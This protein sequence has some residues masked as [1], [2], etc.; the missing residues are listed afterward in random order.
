[1]DETVI[2]VRSTD[3]DIVR[4]VLTQVSAT[5]SYAVV[6]MP[7]GNGILTLQPLDGKLAASLGGN[8]LV[9]SRGLFADEKFATAS[10]SST[11][12]PGRILA[13]VQDLKQRFGTPAIY[14]IGTSNSTLS[15]MALASPLDGQVAGF[16][17]TSSRNAIGDLD[18]HRFKSRHLLV[19]NRKDRCKWCRPSFAQASHDTY[20]TDLIMMD[21]GSNSDTDT[22][23]GDAGCGPFNYHGY[24]GIEKETVD[25]I[26]A[27][28]V[29]GK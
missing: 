17:H 9:R 22:T 10:T 20:G 14:V 19:A 24:N 26:K 15:T 23:P 27:W 21:G 4:Y 2:S 13:I 29:A 5:P 7:G 18:P 6:L 25:K 1:V 12:S 28:I 16:V 11:S 3:G 8:F